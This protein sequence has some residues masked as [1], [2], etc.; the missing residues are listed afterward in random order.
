M[1]ILPPQLRSTTWA[2]WNGRQPNP[3]ISPEHH[4]VVSA[5]VDRLAGLKHFP[6]LL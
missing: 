5:V 1:L 3:K 6:E 4:F 2:I